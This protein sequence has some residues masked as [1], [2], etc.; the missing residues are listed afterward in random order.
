M[1]ALEQVIYLRV[2]LIG[3]QAASLEALD[4]PPRGG[5]ISLRETLEK[6]TRLNTY[7]DSLAISVQGEAI[8]GDSHLPEPSP[9][10]PLPTEYPTFEM[11]EIIA[12]RHAMCVL[13][14][15]VGGVSAEGGM[16]YAYTAVPC[17]ALPTLIETLP[18]RSLADVPM[19]IIVDDLPERTEG[20]KETMFTEYYF[21][22]HQ[23]N[24]RVLTDPAALANA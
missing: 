10:P 8:N 20:L 4:Q 22:E 19:Q 11:A 13:V 24:V 2:G 3:L 23:I 12:L 6:I 14:C 17:T 7:G 15:C 9:L 16:V 5:G 21:A 18:T 1:S